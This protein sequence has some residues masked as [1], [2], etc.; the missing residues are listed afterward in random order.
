MLLWQS[1][2]GIPLRLKMLVRFVRC[3]MMHAAPH[4]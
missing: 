4:L 3:I 1:S 2:F